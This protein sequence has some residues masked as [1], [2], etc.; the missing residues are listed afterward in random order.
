[1]RGEFRRETAPGFVRLFM[2]KVPGHVA[3]AWAS[4]ERVPVPEYF[5]AKPPLRKIAQR[6]VQQTPRARHG[7]F[8]Y[9]LTRQ[10]PFHCFSLR[11]A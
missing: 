4:R 9:A 8:K 5:A 11:A 3:H 7:R 6:S 2:G 10:S 1:M